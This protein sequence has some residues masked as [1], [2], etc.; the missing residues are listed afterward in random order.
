MTLLPSIRPRISMGAKIRV[1]L[2]AE[3]LKALAQVHESTVENLRREAD[4][5]EREGGYE[6]TVEQMRREA[7]WRERR[8]TRYYQRAYTGESA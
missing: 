8:A 3:E 6:S 7:D 4:D 5:Y 2:T 1:T